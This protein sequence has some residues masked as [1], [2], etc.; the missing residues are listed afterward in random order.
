M[1]CLVG[2]AF[3]GAPAFA[4]AITAY[5]T[6]AFDDNEEDDEGSGSKDLLTSIPD[7]FDDEDDDDDD[8][9][10]GSKKSVGYSLAKF[11]EEE[12]EDSDGS[13]SK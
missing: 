1:V 9:G 10:S 12:D 6:P 5:T 13:G 4:T 11:D 2:S 3:K 7:A 8:G